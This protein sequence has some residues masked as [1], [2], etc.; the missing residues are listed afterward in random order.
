MAL[1]VGLCGLPGAGKTTIAEGF[2]G[3]NIGEI[4]PGESEMNILDYITSVINSNDASAIDKLLRDKIDPDYQKIIS[5]NRT[6]G[7]KSCRFYTSANTSI[8]SP[9][10]EYFFSYPIKQ[11]ACALFG[12]SWDLACATT[13]ELRAQRDTFESGIRYRNIPYANG[14]ITARQALQ[15]IG[16]DV[17]RD[18]FD[19]DIWLNITLNRITS[20]NHK[21]A[22]ISDVRFLNEAQAIV[23]AGGK[24]LQVYRDPKDLELTDKRREEHPSNWSFLEFPDSI[25]AERV[26]N[27]STIEH[28]L[29]TV[30]KLIEQ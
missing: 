18:A 9:Y 2:T 27:N 5:D 24:I 8:D 25:I 22:F 23:N 30:K 28:L 7:S 11:I 16:T 10:K 3:T 20:S 13:A 12:F 1:F 26:H 14:I 29:D 21:I 17:F 6:S 4:I 19:P 15:Y